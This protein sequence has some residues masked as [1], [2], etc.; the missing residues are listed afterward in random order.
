MGKL[1]E[2]LVGVNSIELRKQFEIWIE[3]L[4]FGEEN[5]AE[6]LDAYDLLAKSVKE[7]RLQLNWG[8]VTQCIREE[9]DTSRGEPTMKKMSGKEIHDYIRTLEILVQIFP[10]TDE[11]LAHFTEQVG[12][13]HR[14]KSNNVP[15]KLG[16]SLN[17]LRVS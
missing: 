1:S 15:N 8:I 2:H 5:V 4:A 13:Y 16:S 12:L 17:S 11:T 10:F 14:L 3:I 7:K 9:L 6:I